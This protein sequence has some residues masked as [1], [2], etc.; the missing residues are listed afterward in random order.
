[1]TIDNSPVVIRDR[2][3]M[4]ILVISLILLLSVILISDFFEQPIFGISREFY[5][6]TIATLYILINA[7]RF[8]LDLNFINFSD[9]EGKFII[10]YY[11][12]RPFMQKHQSIEIIQ[13]T[14]VKYE[15]ISKAAGLKKYLILYQRVRNKIA[16]YP[17]LSITALTID[18]LNSIL[19]SLN[20]KASTKN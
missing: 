7:Y 1:M 9:Q 14:F 16:K 17:P 3:L 2:K 11:S 19:A 5:A 20:S 13:N 6:I 12:L 18:E 8:F 4:Y 10:R 15:I